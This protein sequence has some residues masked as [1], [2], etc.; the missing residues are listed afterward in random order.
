[1]LAVLMP[2]PKQIDSYIHPAIL[3]AQKQA[4]LKTCGPIALL[5]VSVKLLEK[6]IVNRNGPDVERV[7]PQEKAG[8]R[9]SAAVVIKCTLLPT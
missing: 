8:F 9:A 2:P 6:L 5:S 3:K 7:I 1:M 4:D